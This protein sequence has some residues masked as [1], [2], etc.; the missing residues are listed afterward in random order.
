[1][2][3]LRHNFKLLISD[4]ASYTQ[5]A[6]IMLIH[7]L[8]NLIHITC[9]AHIF[10]NVCLLIKNSYP[11]VDKLIA[12]TKTSTLKHKSQREQ[13]QLVGYP[14]QPVVIRRGSWLKAAIYYSD[15][16]H[17]IKNI[18]NEFE[19]SGLLVKNNQ[20]AVNNNLVFNEL[21]EKGNSYINIIDIVEN[22]EKKAYNVEEMYNLIHSLSFK[23]ILSM[24][25]II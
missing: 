25:R 9:I 16:F 24:Q 23:M 17:T 18:I 1:M 20:I 10:H 22:I 2:G 19:G 4:A 14:P 15:N 12:T 21:M 5:K 11:N 7:L 6:G 3:I 8:T 13:F